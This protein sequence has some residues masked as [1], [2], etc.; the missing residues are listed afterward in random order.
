MIYQIETLTLDGWKPVRPSRGPNTIALPAY[1]FAT[2]V[3]AERMAKLCFDADP[4]TVRV[5]KVEL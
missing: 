1:E 5:T 4:L 3:E 2:K